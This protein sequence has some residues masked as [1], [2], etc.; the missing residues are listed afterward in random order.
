MNPYYTNWNYGYTLGAPTEQTRGAYTQYY[1]N[2][3]YPGQQGVNQENLRDPSKPTG[4]PTKPASS[5]AGGWAQVKGSQPPQPPLKAQVFV[6]ASSTT[7]NAEPTIKAEPTPAR[8]DLNPDF[9]GPSKPQAVVSP[10]QSQDDGGM[11]L[12]KLH[13]VAVANKLVER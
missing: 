5:A 10:T 12:M 9:I 6:T 2:S 7:A 11:S 1:Q 3:A 8:P 13:E 4:S